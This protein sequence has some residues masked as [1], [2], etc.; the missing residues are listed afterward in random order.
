MKGKNINFDYV[1]VINTSSPFI[2]NDDISNSFN[3]IEFFKLDKVIGVIK[4]T[5]N[6]YFHN[7]KGLKQLNDNSYL[8]LERNE[9][10]EEVGGIT[11]FNKKY[12]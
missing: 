12:V 4:Q 11:I 10:Y 5:N 8:R 7:G 9:I 3:I 6:Y 1:Y 2:S